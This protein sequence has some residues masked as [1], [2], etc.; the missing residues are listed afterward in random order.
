MR[1]H[2][3]N[4]GIL[5]TKATPIGAGTIAGNLMKEDSVPF[6]D[7]PAVIE[8]MRK[9]AVEYKSNIGR[10]L[11]NGT[12]FPWVLSLDEYAKLK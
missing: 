11:G 4:S 9:A 2:T 8:K 1:D 10:K 3:A 7:G 5:F 6:K 12:S